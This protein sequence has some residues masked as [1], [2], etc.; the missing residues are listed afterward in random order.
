[1]SATWQPVIIPLTI[2]YSATIGGIDSFAIARVSDVA[3]DG[4]SE[5]YRAYTTIAAAA[6]DLAASEIDQDTYDAISAALSQTPHVQTFYVVKLGLNGYDEA[7]DAA[8]AAGMVA[9]GILIDSR[10][11]ADI[12]TT[13]DWCASRADRTIFVAQSDDAD[14][15]TASTPAGVSTIL[16]NSNTQMVYR[17]T[18]SQQLDAAVLSKRLAWN[19]LITA[20]SSSFSVAGFTPDSLTDSQRTNLIANNANT[21]LAMRNNASG[22]SAAFFGKGRMIDGTRS[23]VITTTIWLS[24]QI[25][26]DVLNLLLQNNDA[27]REIQVAQ[28]GYSAVRGVYSRIGRAGVEAGHFVGSD[29]LPD[30]YQI[31]L[32]AIP[33]AAYTADKANARISVTATYNTAV[34]AFSFPTTVQLTE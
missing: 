9:Q 3:L 22:A 14:W 29:A 18:D 11:D 16:T 12:V 34:G 17:A 19:P 28:S 23:Q 27:G 32:P 21:I 15:L 24:A 4:A 20:G 5:V 25:I 13:S 31:D 30:G 1:M 33:S 7:L 8:E 2:S 26:A 6:T 10:A